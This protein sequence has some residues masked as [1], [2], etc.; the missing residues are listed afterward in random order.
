MHIRPLWILA[1]PVR[2]VAVCAAVLAVWSSTVSP[3][4]AQPTSDGPLASPPNGPRQT[5]PGWHVLTN[6]TVHVRPG[7]VLE[8]TDIEVRGGRI[9]RVGKDLE[10]PGARVWDLSGRHVY[11]GLIDP[12]RAVEAGSLPEDEPGRHWNSLVL[13]QRSVLAGPGLSEQGR[14][15]LRRQGFVAAGLVPDS[16]IFR[17]GTAVISLGAPAE[18]PSQDPP[19]VYRASVFHAVAFDTVRGSGYPNSGMG[20]LALIRQTVL[21]A[22]W[23]ASERARGTFSEPSNCLDALADPEV[24]LLILADDELDTLRAGGLGRE[25]SRPV[26]VVGSGMEF[27]RFDAVVRDGVR[28]VLPLDFPDAPDVSTVGAA[29]AAE[30]ETLMN[31]EQ[32]PTNPRRFNDAGLHVSLT[33]HGLDNPAQL[34]K[35][36]RYAMRHGL[37][38]DTA[39]AM[40]TTRPAELLGVDDRLG[41]IEPGKI[42][43]LIVADGPLFGEDTTILDVWVDGR[44][45]ENERDTD[46]D[47]DGHWTLRV[48]D[49]VIRLEID[50]RKITASEGDAEGRARGV[51]IDHYRLHFILDDEDDGSSSYLM[52][53]VI[54]GD[55]MTGVGMSPAGAAFQWTA[56]REE[57]EPADPDD[58]AAD[59]DHP[60]AAGAQAV[61]DE[62]GEADADEVSAAQAAG[63]EGQAEDP[64]DGPIAVPE[65]IRYPFGPYAVDQP[66]AQRAM[67]ITGATI[68][69][70]GEQGIIEDGALLTSADGTV[71][72]VGPADGVRDSGIPLPAGLVEID[73]SGK[74]I[75]PGLIDCHSHTGLE[76]FGIN[77]SGQ[78][79]TAE[80]RISDSLDPG[81]VDFYRQLAGGVTTVNSLHGSANP[82]GGQN[83]V[84]RLRWG[85]L[86]PEDTRFEGAPTGIKF[87]LGENVKQSNWGRNTSRYPQ[88]RMGVETLIRDRFIAAREYA[89]A[90]EAFEGGAG[91]GHAPRRDLELEALAQVL[92]GERLVHCHSYRQDEI[93][94][95][96]RVAE[97]F[98][99]TIGTFQHVLEGYKVADEI[100]RHSLGASAFSDWWAYKVEVQDAIPFNGALMHEV[101]VVVSFNSDSDELARRMNTE[102]AKAVRYGGVD[103]HEALKFVTLNPA[104]QLGIADRVGSLEAGKDADFVI[105]SGDPLSSFSR[106]EATYI[107]SAEYFS[108]EQDAAHRERIAQERSRLIHRILDEAHP[109]PD[110]PAAEEDHDGHDAEGTHPEPGSVEAIRAANIR[111]H[112]LRMLESGEDATHWHCG[113]CGETYRDLN[114]SGHHGHNH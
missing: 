53:G 85:V 63:G 82:I 107:Q 70:S 3:T 49:L 23:Q 28:L 18:D 100:A 102:A 13:P 17:G 32:A 96:C 71:L 44:R 110:R 78:A 93:L 10:V 106:C 19:P 87:A 48:G 91:D 14:A 26:V 41:T 101:G 27:R 94:M 9:V 11:A 69:T 47:F 95:L 5:D 112:Y 50:G 40:L 98:G 52:S 104:I 58:H 42:A 51:S 103:P 61:G 74:H 36:V 75:T 62:A 66:P 12:C 15:A 67:L 79:V 21:D 88:T 22:D 30:L 90:W 64:D 38:A 56:V 55:R 92:A 43:G 113:D 76:S 83:L 16:G 84:Q 68:W 1:H 6:A 89:A 65:E 45:Y 97:E 4:I 105:W 29:D 60:G 59:Q 109:R 114:H 24:P 46:G 54:E 7:E 31:W 20:S 99:F 57:P 72:Y 108:L 80:V 111:N 39:L 34:Y 77:E 37:E 2:L 35:R 73:A 86:H 81:S 25:L 8:E 33:T